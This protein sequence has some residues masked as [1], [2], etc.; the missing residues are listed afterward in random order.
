MISQQGSRTLMRAKTY[1]WL[2]NSWLAYRLQREQTA[3]TA[4]GADIPCRAEPQC[5]R[6]VTGSEWLVCRSEVAY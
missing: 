4:S 5:S 2:P 6:A 3:G 1:E